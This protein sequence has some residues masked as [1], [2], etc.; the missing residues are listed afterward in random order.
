INLFECFL[1]NLSGIL[2]KNPST[3]PN[4]I[5]P[6]ISTK[7]KRAVTKAEFWPGFIIEL[8]IAIT[9]PKA[10][11]ATASSNAT[12]LSNVLVTGPFALYC[13]I[14][15]TVAAGAVA[16]AIAPNS[17]DVFGSKPNRINTTVTNIVAN[18]ASN[19]A[20]TI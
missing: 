11:N 7:G 9:N 6:I 20:I 15:I 4:A 16:A 14:T 18:N 13:F 2:N 8:T 5:E 10:I 1:K 3:I 12:T 19:K 17:I